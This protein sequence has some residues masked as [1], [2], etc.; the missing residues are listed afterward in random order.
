MVCFVCCCGCCYGLWFVL[1]LWFVLFAD[2]CCLF[3]SVVCFV[4]CFLFVVSCLL[5]WS[6][7]LWLLYGHCRY[8]CCYGLFVVVVMVIVGCCYFHLVYCWLAGPWSGNR[9]FLDL[10]ELKR[11]ALRTEWS[12]EGSFGHWHGLGHGQGH[13]EYCVVVKKCPCL[14]LSLLLWSL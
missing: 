3:L 9:V 8:G 13:K 4:C 1:C 14:L 6:L 12:R 2:V 10:W 11:R 7:L 5:L